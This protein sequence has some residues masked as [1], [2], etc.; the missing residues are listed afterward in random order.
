MKLSA[1]RKQLSAYRFKYDRTFVESYAPTRLSW[2]QI[3]VG[4]ISARFRVRI[5]VT[6]K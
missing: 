4:G 5:L 6:E 3:N 1:V 2:V